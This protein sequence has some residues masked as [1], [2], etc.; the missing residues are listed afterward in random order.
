MSESFIPHPS[1]LIPSARIK[2]FPGLR[3]FLAEE[4]YLFFGREEQTA[5]LLSLLR[6]HRFLAVVGTSGSGK[7]SLV[8]AGLLPALHGGTL[9]Q[10]GSAWEV[11]VV[12]PGG[13]PID[14]LARAL[15]AADLYD[16]EDVESLPR[17]VATLTR[18][19]TGLVEAVKQSDLAEKT[20]FLVVVD[21]FEELFRFRQSAVGGQEESA[22]FVRLLLA[23]CQQ[24][25]RPIYVAI[26][27]RSDYL[28]DCAQIPGLAEAV[29]DGE[30]LIP[31]LSREQRRA[32]IEK[33]VRVGGGSIAPRLTHQLL[34]DVG[35]DP[36]QLPVLQHA[37]MRIWDCWVADHTD[38]EPLDLAHYQRIGG[39][40]EALS[41]HADEAYAE[42]PSD[43]HRLLARK[44][45]QALTERGAD[46]RGIR[47]PTRFD[48]LCAVLDAPP[49]DVAAVVEAFRQAGRTF[50]MPMP[51]V[52]LT[53]QTVIDLSH[54]SLMRVWQ[55]LRGWVEEESQSARIYRR[56]ADTAL[57]HQE[58]KAGFY[59]DPDLQIARSW[60]ERAQPNAAWAERY[61]AGFDAAV[62]F[63][64]QNQ[65]ESRAAEKARE[66]AR[67]RELEQ[68]RQLA[69]AQQLRLQQQQRAARKLRK[70][71]A[72]LAVV[73]I[74]AAFACV[75][76]LV[77]RHEAGKLAETAR[78]NEQKADEN[79]TAALQSAR[80]AQAAEEEGRKLLYTTDMQ[81]APFVWKDDHFTAAQLST[82]LTKHIPDNNA[83]VARPD[84]RGF[85]W[86]YYQHL[87]ENSAAVFS[88]HETALAGGAFAS[89]GQLVTLDQDGQVR[90]W[91]VDSQDEDKAGRRD[92][93]GGRGAQNRVLSPN[94]RLAAL[95]EGDKVYV[96]DTSTG[97]ETCEIDSAADHFRG[98]IF[99]PDNERLVIVDDKI[100]WVSAGSGEVI[101]SIDQKFDRLNSPVDP[102]LAL[103]ADGL[104]L[105]VV[106]HGLGGVLF[107]S[108]H[109][110]A[111]A[112]KVTRLAKDAGSDVYRGTLHACAL[113]PDGQRIALGHFFTGRIYVCDTTTGRTIAQHW[114]A[115]AA[116]HRA[117]AF[118]SDGT[119]L[120]TADAEGTIKIWADAEQLNSKST[121]LLTLKGHQGAITTIGFSSDG[122]QLLTTS[123]D[124]TARVWD[125]EN[126]GT[127]IR[128]VQRT[129]GT[130]VARFS[131]DGQ[132]IAC[133][134]SR[135]VRF[136]DAATG[137]LVRE[138]PPAEKGSIYS[139]AFSP[140]DHRLLAV[141]YGG[142]EDVSYVALW[143]IDAGTEL[144]RLPGATD[145]EGFA[146]DA[147]RRVVGALAFSPD[148]KYLAAGFGQKYWFDPASSPSPLKVWEV[149]N[150]RL[151]RRLDGHTHLCLSLD[152]SRDGK[153]LASGS[154]D[155]TAIVWSTETWKAIETVENPDHD[156]LYGGRGM[157]EDVAFSPDGKTL[158][159]ASREGDV[160]LWDVAGRKFLE[161]L[162][163][164]SSAVLAVA[165][166]PDGRTLASCGTGLTVHLWNVPTR[167]H[168][169]QL[170]PSGIE[171]GELW[172]LAFS[173]D[174][175]QLLAGG[176]Q[177]SAFWSAAPSVW[178]D[179]V[180]AAE[181]LRLLL[182]SNADFQRRVRML[183]AD[184]RL[185]ES[186]EKLETV[187]PEDIRVRS[188][189]AATQVRY[190]AEQRNAALADA[191]RA[192]ARALLEQQLAAE[193]D[194]AAIAAELAEL[195]LPQAESAAWTELKPI[196]AKSELGATLSILADNSIL[197]SGA[198][199]SLDRY[200]VVLTPPAAVNVAAVRLEA[201]THPSLPR[202]GPG[203]A[204]SGQFSQ[205]WWNVTA[206]S[207]DRE[208]PV[209]LEF[210]RALADREMAGYPANSSGHW[211]ISL[212]G[213]GRDC[214]AL[215]SLSKPVSLERNA[216]LIFDM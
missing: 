137:R 170:D 123:A 131:P 106:G 21:Q 108:F 42:L 199:A 145:L 191:A 4:D 29:N 20:N 68:A 112:K 55:R 35:D 162:E 205:T 107:S 202:H 26:T 79:A 94:G 12:R 82:L 189:L 117:M 152:F 102:R 121:A 44:L 151:I 122:K 193:P 96:F 211:N 143:D 184:R 28:G 133:S 177:G 9:A 57:L 141:G 101:A 5:E 88:G 127:A 17:L 66:A 208:E 179:P 64:D 156:S 1:S 24:A 77:A 56:L 195:L 71:V 100:R 150:R 8:R 41:L 99:S 149:A 146:A 210:G 93:P 124:K 37:L 153:L 168:L 70:L 110:D 201:L 52:P 180:R 142:Q 128:P 89:E 181:K 39:L 62:A 120:A 51:E 125:L 13:N 175:M 76:A 90:R 174:G 215:W 138:L 182:E 48:Q 81:L 158:A 139:V 136:W 22:A 200:H 144:A 203:R 63:L 206:A 104:T 27:M 80:Q 6:Q 72:G 119:R 3:P 95:A 154:R 43:H 59:R 14:N 187:F 31:R 33:P 45:F 135:S 155:G 73:A 98:L 61:H 167:S 214:T 185:L 148:G 75:A 212:S 36:D 58:G 78:Q 30:Y 116:P 197:A 171:L 194:N 23:A 15:L 19:R 65:Q 60:R 67:Q 85:E 166:S 118:S 109:L 53:P 147:G 49:T 160:Q 172:S 54:E 130:A 140:T 173:P 87:L 34:N 207:P 132:L 86:H 84:L 11:T 188:A 113:S 50:L 209:R 18:S 178:N 157:V 216:T 10:A 169:M 186:L 111:A 69:E 91:D 196:E 46:N 159:L 74:I 183:P 165:F 25:E 192:K 7:S 16:A 126:G 103:S 134:H 190:F 129:G 2:P 176:L 83:T 163:G 161:P 105:A 32:A 38:G 204:P 198:S 92:L 115:H 97:K 40:Q 213:E 47:R 114:T 164:H